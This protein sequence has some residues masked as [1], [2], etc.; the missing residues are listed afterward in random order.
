GPAGLCGVVGLKPT[1]DLVSRTGVFP[2]ASTLDHIGPMAR[3]VA[4]AATLLDAL[5][6]NVPGRRFG[7]DL[8]R[9]VRGL[10]I[11]FVRQFHE[12]DMVAD[13]EVGVALDQ[14]ARVL[15]A[16]GAE[17]RDISLPRLQ[18]FTS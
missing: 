8:A 7:T 13:A 6:G 16:E 15:E 12:I 10:R 17:V 14:V 9:G 11:G 18:Q 4:D 3:S 1:Y 2:L 5:A